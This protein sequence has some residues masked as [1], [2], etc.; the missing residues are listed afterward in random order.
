MSI[1]GILEVLCIIIISGNNIFFYFIIT[2]L[3]HIRSVLPGS[4]VTRT[5]E[6]RLSVN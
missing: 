3:Y 1:N 4:L 5:G 2:I 6:N